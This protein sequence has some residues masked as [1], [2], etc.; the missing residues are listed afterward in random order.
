MGTAQDVFYFKAAH[1]THMMAT[2]RRRVRLLSAV[3]KTPQPDTAIC[4]SRSPPHTHT[5]LGN[6]AHTYM[7]LVTPSPSPPTQATQISPW[8]VTWEAL[9]PFVCDAPSQD[10]PVL[11]Y[12]REGRRKTVDIKLA[13]E[14][15]PPEA[16][17]QSCPVSHTNFNT[18]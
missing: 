15:V 11:P 16:P 7:L 3:K 9:Q 6:P 13:A 10:P 17:G 1:V 4:Y 14:I 8:V 18:M 12:L 5:L 2:W